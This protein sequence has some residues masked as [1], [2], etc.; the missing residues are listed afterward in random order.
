MT[1]ML[2]VAPPGGETHY[3]RPGHVN[4]LCGAERVSN[5]DVIGEDPGGLVTAA[6][7]VPTCSTC[8]ALAGQQ[9]YAHPVGG[10]S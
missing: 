2:V 3:A 8:L 4:C 10:S 1:A 6:M 5:A 9:G 7:P